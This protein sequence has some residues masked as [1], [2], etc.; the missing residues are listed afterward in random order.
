MHGRRQ[1]GRSHRFSA[2]AAGRSRAKRDECAAADGN[3][4]TTHVKGQR[5]REQTWLERWRAPRPRPSK[6]RVRVR[7]EVEAKVGG[8]ELI[9]GRVSGDPLPTPP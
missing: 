2:A 4:A 3:R 8:R 5:R 1:V 9:A 7:V 6:A